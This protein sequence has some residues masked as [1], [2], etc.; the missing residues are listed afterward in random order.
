MAF[1][2]RRKLS[3]SVVSWRS[4]R[5]KCAK[6]CWPIRSWTEPT[7]RWRISCTRCRTTS[8]THPRCVLI[9]ASCCYIA[10]CLWNP[11]P[12]SPPRSAWQQRSTWPKS[13]GQISSSVVFAHHA[14][15]LVQGRKE[16]IK[17]M[18]SENA[19]KA[20]YAKQKAHNPPSSP[21]Q[22]DWLFNCCVSVWSMNDR[23]NPR[24]SHD[25]AC[26]RWLFQ[27]FLFITMLFSL[28]AWEVTKSLLPIVAKTTVGFCTSKTKMT[29]LFRR[30]LNRVKKKTSESLTYIVLI[31]WSYLHQKPFVL[32]TETIVL[33]A[34][35]NCVYSSFLVT[36][37]SPSLGVN[38]NE[39]RLAKTLS[40]P[41]GNCSLYL[42]Y[43][44]LQAHWTAEE[45][46]QVQGSHHWA[47]GAASA[48]CSSPSGE[49]DRPT[50]KRR[51]DERPRNSGEIQI[52]TGILEC[53][54]RHFRPRKKKELS[55]SKMSHENNMSVQAKVK[56]FTCNFVC[57]LLLL[58]KKELLIFERFTFILVPKS[59]SSLFTARTYLDRF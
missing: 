39:A 45:F 10:R 38:I 35:I 53:V 34:S 42:V 59:F 40:F 48:K 13:C 55:T 29:G 44:G 30:L 14:V 20:D 57:L 37:I 32:L 25:S 54:T 46:G 26:L 3:G 31:C 19:I 49:T 15:V 50:A 28:W 17:M 43:F 12:P 24:W 47:A 9:A 1:A 2:I 18:S 5:R 11:L 51:P 23:K 33:T 16:K 21:S 27:E 7:C 6:F 36:H 8:P 56:C 58:K 41:G 4:R 22:P 52:T